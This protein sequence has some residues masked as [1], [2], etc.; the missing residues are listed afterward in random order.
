MQEIN[1]I[2]SANVFYAER[3][4]TNTTPLWGGTLCGQGETYMHFGEVLPPSPGFL[5]I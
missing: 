4:V 1:D 2:N 5:G 3:D